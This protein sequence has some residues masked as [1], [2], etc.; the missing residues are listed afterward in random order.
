MVIWT[1]VAGGTIPGINCTPAR[2]APGRPARS[3]V[4]LLGLR[5]NKSTL[6]VGSWAH[7]HHE[8]TSAQGLGLGL[9]GPAAAPRRGGAGGRR[10][11]GASGLWGRRGGAAGA[12]RGRRAAASANRAAG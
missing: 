12:P 9:R 10:D 1:V 6:G 11:Q 2:R 8:R 7:D 4:E 3:S 5:P